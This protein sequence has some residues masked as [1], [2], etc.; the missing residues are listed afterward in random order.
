MSIVP[1]FSCSSPSLDFQ[2]FILY[3]FIKNYTRESLLLLLRTVL[4]LVN[5][6]QSVWF[7]KCIWLCKLGMLGYSIS[8][9]NKRK[10]SY[11]FDSV[12]LQFIEVVLVSR[13]FTISTLCLGPSDRGVRQKKWWFDK[14]SY[15][16]SVNFYYQYCWYYWTFLRILY[17]DSL[18]SVLSFNIH[19]YQYCY[20][21]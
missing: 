2:G 19:V 4:D 20:F 12:S 16:T 10:I 13:S 5:D 3:E 1:K 21:F 18:F 15:I 17:Y 7:M 6:I 8:Y 9:S 11:P 14:F